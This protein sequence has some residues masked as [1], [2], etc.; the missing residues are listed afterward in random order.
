MRK[1][2]EGGLV[3]KDP[4]SESHE[5]SLVNLLP[6]GNLLR[7]RIVD[8]A[9]EINKGRTDHEFKALFGHDKNY[10]LLRRLR[11]AF[12]N[13][14][15]EAQG[16]VNPNMVIARVHSGLTTYPTFMKLMNDDLYA[17]FVLTQPHNIRLIQQD[18]LY[19]GYRHFEE[20]LEADIY[21]DKGRVQS[22]LI[23]HK[24]RI[25]EMLQN[26]L[27]G[28]IVQR[29]QIYSEEVRTDNSPKNE[30]DVAKLREEIAS[31]KKDLGKDALPE[32]SYVESN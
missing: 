16:A 17:T 20:I 25:I 1:V 19:E 14:Y 28:S 15:N 6:E 21:D 4:F 18:L 27:E 8:L 22:S 7:E 10:T 9:D 13:Q 26:R 2:K 30:Q 12:W 29:Q 11:F 5:R 23:G 3:F 32:V 24:I 31:L